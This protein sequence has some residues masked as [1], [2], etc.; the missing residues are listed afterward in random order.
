[1]CYSDTHKPSIRRGR[2]GKV[3]KI[4]KAQA[5]REKEAT[6]VLA[7][8]CREKFKRYAYSNLG[9]VETRKVLDIIRDIRFSTIVFVDALT[10]KRV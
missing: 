5:K 6:I 8:E 7:G 1:M 4:S 2:E 10:G 9:F 3:M